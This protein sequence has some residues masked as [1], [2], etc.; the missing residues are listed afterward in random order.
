MS[1]LDLFKALSSVES[2]KKKNSVTFKCSFVTQDL[3]QKNWKAME[4]LS[5]AEKT[6][7]A[8]INKALEAAKVLMTFCP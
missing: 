5:E 8:Q 6:A 3:R 4:A 2:L 1:V 7:Q